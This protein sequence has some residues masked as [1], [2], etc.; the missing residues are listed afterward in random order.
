MLKVVSSTRVSVK[1]VSTS[2]FT[3]WINV[4]KA[5]KIISVKKK[6]ETERKEKY[7]FIFSPARLL[8]YFRACQSIS[9]VNNQ[10][11]LSK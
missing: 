7:P 3:E 11:S 10:A 6:E 4:V 2:R 5:R 8:E 1:R 9:C